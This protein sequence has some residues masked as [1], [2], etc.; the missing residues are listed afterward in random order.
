MTTKRSSPKPPKYGFMKRTALALP[1]TMEVIDRHG[2]W[3]NIG[4][5][6]F[7]LS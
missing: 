7:A 3:L 2:Y 5:K 6:T 1:G 4:K